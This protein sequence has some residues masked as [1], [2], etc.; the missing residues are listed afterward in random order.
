VRRLD[1]LAG[2]ATVAA[3]IA[4]IWL[5]FTPNL[6]VGEFVLLM[7]LG[8]FLWIVFFVWLVS[9]PEGMRR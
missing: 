1:D 4:V 5:W 6:S 7:L 9:K 3:M 2:M 8:A